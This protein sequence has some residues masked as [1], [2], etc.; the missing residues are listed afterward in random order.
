MYRLHNMKPGK[1][2]FILRRVATVHAVRV[3]QVYEEKSQDAYTLLAQVRIGRGRRRFSYFDIHAAEFLSNLAEELRDA[4]GRNVFFD[5]C[6]GV[7]RVPFGL[8]KSR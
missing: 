6:D 2:E 8:T 4:V 3:L 1:I 7:I 5:V